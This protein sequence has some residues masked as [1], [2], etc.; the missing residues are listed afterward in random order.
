[1]LSPLFTLF[2]PLFVWW[3]LHVSNW[4][5]IWRLAYLM[6]LPFVGAAL[7]TMSVNR[8]VSQKSRLGL[9]TITFMVIILV[10]S[11]APINWRYIYNDNP[12]WSSLASVEH[13]NGALLWGDLIDV[14][15]NLKGEEVPIFTDYVTNY[16]LSTATPHGITSGAK[17]RWQTRQNAFYGDYKDRLLYW[18]HDGDFLIINHRDG[19]FSE[20]GRLSGHWWDNIL[21]VKRLYPVGLREFVDSHP[22]DFELLWSADKIWVYKLLINPEHYK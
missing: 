21:K 9:I 2:N 5:P 13:K 10:G 19:E 1:M 14:V 17:S 7:I 8:A 20:T 11:L 18:R 12:R 3:F 6:P 16:V 15:G 4:D 22:E